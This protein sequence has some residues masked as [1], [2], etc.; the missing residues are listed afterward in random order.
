MTSIS[1][2]PDPSVSLDLDL[3]ERPPEDESTPFVVNINGRKITMVDPDTL[4]WRD[5]IT[6]SDPTDFIRIAMSSEDRQYLVK[7]AIPGWKFSRLLE[8]YYLHY[9]LDEKIAAARRRGSLG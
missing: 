4:D 9:D 7:Q 1:E 2:L 6:M 3:L 5:L 8:S